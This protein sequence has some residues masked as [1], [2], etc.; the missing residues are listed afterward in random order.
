MKKSF[1][2]IFGGIIIGLVFGFAHPQLQTY[3]VRREN[4]I[5]EMQELI[6]ER[7]EVGEYQCCIEPACD[8]CYLGHWIWDD[9][10]CRCDEMIAKG[11]FDKVCP[12]CEKAIEEGQCKSSLETVCT[13]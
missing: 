5:K 2:L 9:G 4:N 8:M 1:V 13:L 7:V 10:I 11:E 12:Q 6:G 3:D